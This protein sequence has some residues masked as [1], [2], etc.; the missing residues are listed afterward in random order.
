MAGPSS[1]VVTAKRGEGMSISEFPAVVAAGFWWGAFIW[2]SYS[3]FFY[4][5]RP[6]V[7]REG[8]VL[9]KIWHTLNNNHYY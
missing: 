3:D 9:G 4:K 5:Y 8:A 2:K 7:S 1:S 6:R